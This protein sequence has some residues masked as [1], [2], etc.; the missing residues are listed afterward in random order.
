MKTKVMVLGVSGM[1]GSTMTIN[2]KEKFQ[3]F[4]VYNQEGVKF[5][6]KTKQFPFNKLSDLRDL[7][8]KI[9]PTYIINCLGIIPQNSTYHQKSEVLYLNGQFP[10]EI[11][12]IITGRDSQLIQ[13]STDCVFN[14]SRG[15]RIESDIP[16]AKGL[17]GISKING[18]IIDDQ[19]LTLRTSIIGHEI[20]RKK[21]LL[22]W[23]L[24]NDEKLIEGYSKAYFSGL[25][26]LELSNILSEYMSSNSRLSGL[27][28]ISGPKINK[29]ELLKLINKI[30]KK[31]IVIYENDNFK[32][33]RSLNSQKAIKKSIYKPK[34]WSEMI[35]E[36]C[37]FYKK[38][39][40][41]FK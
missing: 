2:L 19:N 22:E 31:N 35:E 1:L 10:H 15:N 18:E 28:Q 24:N 20:R 5:L 14:G 36:Q 3:I 32:I 39:I 16:D 12:K 34:S 13:I 38:N 23:F 7:I 26:T 30:Y 17:Y 6:D 33:D 29:F 8:L 21:S 25:T 11:T 40:S 4:G 9:K 37:E 41:T 27:Y